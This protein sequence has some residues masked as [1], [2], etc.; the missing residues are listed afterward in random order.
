MNKELNMIF[1]FSRRKSF[2][3]LSWLI[4]LIEGT[5]YSHAYVKIWS[6]SLHR[7]L[8]YQATSKGGLHFCSLEKFLEKNIAV[9]EYSVKETEQERI[10]ILVK[11]VDYA[12][13]DYSIMQLLGMAFVRLMNWLGRKVKNPW[14]HGWVCSEVQY[15][16]LCDLGV[17]ITEDRNIVS[18]KYLRD[19]LLQYATEYKQNGRWS[20]VKET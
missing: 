5:G 2:N 1:G 3:P 16:F 18:P 4:M 7:W 8:I 20:K 10:R 11:C 19:I 14:I 9:E 17:E 13:D 6:E 15:E 12:A